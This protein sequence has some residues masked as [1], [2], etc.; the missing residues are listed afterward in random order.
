M[1]LKV[2]GS[3]VNPEETGLTKKDGANIAAEFTHGDKS[4][5]WWKG[6]I[7]DNLWSIAE[8]RLPWLKTTIADG[9][10]SEEQKPT[11]Q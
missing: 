4:L 2:D 9:K 3:E 6:V 10:F 8:N 1:T 11:V 5:S 7:G